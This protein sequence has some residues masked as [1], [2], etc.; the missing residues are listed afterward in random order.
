MATVPK[1]LHTVTS[2]LRVARHLK[3][4][5]QAGFYASA[6]CVDD[7]FRLLGYDPSGSGWDDSHGL[8][9]K[10]VRLMESGK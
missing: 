4:Q 2:V 9:D 7:A 5:R 8:R 10:C 6:A 1:S 3:S